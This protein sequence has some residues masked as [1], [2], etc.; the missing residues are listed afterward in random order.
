MNTNDDFW[1]D[2]NCPCNGCPFEGL[3]TLEKLACEDFR[4]YSE[5]GEHRDADRH[6]TA[7]IYRELFKNVE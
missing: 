6:P 1:Y 3:C 2:E 5:T 7:A 4:Y